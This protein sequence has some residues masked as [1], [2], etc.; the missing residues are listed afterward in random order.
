MF[1][2]LRRNNSSC[3]FSFLSINITRTAIV[4]KI[5]DNEILQDN[6]HPG[7]EKMQMIIRKK[8]LVVQLNYYYAVVV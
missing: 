7:Y 3:S 6:K 8:M 5:S 4:I 1:L 2:E